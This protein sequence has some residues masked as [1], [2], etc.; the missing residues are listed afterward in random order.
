MLSI[1]SCTYWLFVGLIE[2][3]AIQTLC[4][5]FHWVICHCTVE[6]ESFRYSKYKTFIRYD[7]KHFLLF[8]G[9]SFHILNSILWCTN[10]YF[11]ESQLIYFSCVTW[12][13]GTILKKPLATPKYTKMYSYIVFCFTV[14]A[15]RFRSMI[16]FK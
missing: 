9:L 3:N 8:C 11:D 13:F 6:Q 10:I 4:P 16:H 5:Y 14:L 15:L 12:A 1:L 7:Y 2:K